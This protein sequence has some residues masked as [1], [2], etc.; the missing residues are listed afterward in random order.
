MVRALASLPRRSPSV[1]PSSTCS[2]LNAATLGTLTPVPAIDGK[3]FGRVLTVNLVANQALL[4]AFDGALAGKR[5]RPGARAHIQCRR[6]PAR[7]LGRLWRVKAALETMVLS[8]AEEV[9]SFGI[10]VAIVDPGATATE[11]R[12][13]AFPGRGPGTIKEPAAVGEAHRS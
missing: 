6:P 13:R 5:N 4:A 9:R 8:Y 10:R 3:E 2:C 11:M 1:G 7:L 12:V